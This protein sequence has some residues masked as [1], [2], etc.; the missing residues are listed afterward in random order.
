MW[1]EVANCIGQNISLS[2]SWKRCTINQC[3]SALNW[4]NSFMAHNISLWIHLLDKFLQLWQKN[5]GQIDLINA[6]AAWWHVRIAGRELVVVI[7]FHDKLT[8]SSIRGQDIIENTKWPGGRLNIK[9]SSYQYRD[10]HVKDKTVSPT[11]LSLTWES[12]ITGKDGIYI[13]TGSFVI[14]GNGLATTMWWRKWDHKKF[15]VEQK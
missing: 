2:S 3:K 11:V 8:S 1:Q 7:T 9:M 14:F 6:I 5:T 12:P 13:E 10:S 15:R 4:V